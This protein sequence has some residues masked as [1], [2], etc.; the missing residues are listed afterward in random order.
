MESSHGEGTAEHFSHLF[1]RPAACW[2]QFKLVC[3]EDVPVF[4]VTTA[5]I[6]APCS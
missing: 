2:L 4:K 3:S 6:K 1:L 5:A